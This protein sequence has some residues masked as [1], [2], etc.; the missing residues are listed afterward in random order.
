MSC[1]IHRRGNPQCEQCAGVPAPDS[2]RPARVVPVIPDLTT[3]SVAARAGAGGS[4]LP[5][6]R[7]IRAWKNGPPSESTQRRA[8]QASLR[9]CAA[10]RAA[11]KLDE[12]LG[13]VDEEES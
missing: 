6:A 12:V 7:Q 8:L 1:A 2:I 3:G 10:K 9:G 5:T 13:P 11:V 4:A